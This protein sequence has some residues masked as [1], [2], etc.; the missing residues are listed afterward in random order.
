MTEDATVYAHFAKSLQDH[1][2][3]FYSEDSRTL[4]TTRKVKHGSALTDLPVSTKAEDAYQRYTFAKWVSLDGEDVSF[5]SVTGDMDVRASFTASFVNHFSDLE[6]GRWYTE[7]AREALVNGMMNG[8]SNTKFSP[9]A[10]ASRAMFVTV[11]WR[12]EGAPDGNSQ[13]QL[14]FTDVK[15][16]SYYEDAVKWAYTA[17]VVSG[18][19]DTSFAPNN[20]LTREQLATM[21]Y[22]YAEQIR[23]YDMGDQ[24]GDNF[25]EFADRSQIHDY[26]KEALL[27]MIAEE[28]GYLQG[29][30]SGDDL[31]LQ[32][33]VNANRAM[34]A[35]ILSRF[36]HTNEQALAE[37]FANPSSEFS[38]MPFWFWNDTLVEQDDTVDEY[39]VPKGIY[40]Q[41][42]AFKEKGVDGFVIHPR[43]GLDSSI[44]YMGETWLHY[45]RYAVELAAEWDMKVVLYDEAMYPSGSAHGMVVNGSGSLGVEANPEYASRGLEMRESPTLGKDEILLGQ[46]ERDGKTYYFVETYTN[47]H[48]RGVY[49]GEDDNQAGAP[50]SADLLNP[51]AVDKFIALTHEKYYEALSEYFGNTVIAIFTDEPSISGR[52]CKAGQMAWTG[53]LEQDGLL[54]ELKANGVT[55][56]E[57][58]YLFYPNSARG[59]QVKAI[60]DN[61]IYNR[62]NNVYYGRLANWCEAHKI[63]LTGHPGSSMDIGLLDNFDIP[64]QDIVWN[65]IDPAAANGVSN[66]DSTMGKC[67]SDHARHTGKRR[68]GN[69]CFGACGSSMQDFTY[70]KMKWYLDWLFVRGCNFVIPHAF[71]YSVRGDRGNERPPE[72]G[73]RSL[74]W[75]DYKT[76]SDY[77]KRCS[78]MNTD[79]VNITDVAILCT[80]DQLSWQAARPLFENQIEFN[81]LECDL[82][83]PA[84]IDHGAYK[85]GKQSYRVIITDRAGYDTETD[86]FLKAFTKAGGTVIRY[87]GGAAYV[88]NVR[89]ASMTDV[90]VDVNNMLRVTHVRKYGKD[91]LYFVN[92]G[93][94]TITTTLHQKVAEVW[95]AKT[96]KMLENFSG[97]EYPLTLE[98]RQSVYLILK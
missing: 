7:A 54:A 81:Y 10:A 96:G 49:Y 88:N 35:T 31:Y 41:M 51:D 33:R 94:Q 4:I 57:L 78:A 86:A 63:A 69:E 3:R 75:D 14:P 58:Y 83:D 60:Y 84:G 9:T 46:T 65:Y 73:M 45:V 1:T 19:T 68:N 38:P 70:D 39:G 89:G 52:F 26:A 59:A 12:L 37:E 56:D 18:V 53:G 93:E 85:I 6:E 15:A 72:V 32:P 79:S 24:S 21:L 77:I 47:G 13:F 98:R 25:I 90:D 64:C 48:I 2:V 80:K 62:L 50:P 55:E 30:P 22:R 5:D 29:V 92:E 67:A 20:S 76:I 23:Y 87:S 27:W 61:I 74:F 42:K 11:L 95:D 44:E 43:M 8:V 36:R 16:G 17:G 28:N 91:V 82:L 40:D 71:F 34:M 97:D 66:D